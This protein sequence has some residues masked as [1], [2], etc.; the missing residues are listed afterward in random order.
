MRR[1]IEDDEDNE[2]NE[3]DSVIQEDDM[4]YTS[5]RPGRPRRALTSQPSTTN[6]SRFAWLTSKASSLTSLKSSPAPAASDLANDPL[7]NLDVSG[8]LFPHGPADPLDPTSFHDLLTNAESL[9]A[10]LQAGYRAK[11]AALEDLRREQSVQVEELDEAETR[12]RHL[13]TQLEDMS[14]K[15][16]ERERLNDELTETL[17]QERRRFREDEERRRRSIR[18]VRSSDDSADLRKLHHTPTPSVGS[19]SGFES[20][21]ESEN[22]S[23]FSR[24]GVAESR[25]SADGQEYQIARAMRVK[26]VII[27][28]DSTAC[29]NCHGTMMGASDLRSENH[30]LRIRVA[31]LEEAV[32]GCLDLVGGR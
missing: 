2:D 17:V 5:A 30:I 29:R 8:E 20:D 27:G 13:R 22:G 23:V 18:K 24:S 28:S 9:I 10:L 31:E 32:E 12:T 1:G 7:L 6:S 25:S 19:D 26:P 3:D 15:M 11:C 14:H 21:P 4:E 16:A